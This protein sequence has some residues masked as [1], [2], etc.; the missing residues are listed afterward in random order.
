MGI[1][2]VWRRI[3]A[4]EGETFRQVRGGEFTY[5]VQGAVLRPDRTNRNLHRSQFEAALQR[6]PISG[7]SDLQDLQGPSYLF[8]ILT[9]P[10]IRQG[11]W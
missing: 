4:H 2:E 5:E 7:P 1:D 3:T 11:D 6:A 8:A 10:R 9:D